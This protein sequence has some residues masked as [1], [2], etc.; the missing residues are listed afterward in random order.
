M[1][2]HGFDPVYLIAFG[3]ALFALEAVITS[4]VVIWFAVASLIV[5]LASFAFDMSLSVQIGAISIIG[6]ALLLWLRTSMYAKFMAAKGEEAKDIF[7]DE[8]GTGVISNG[9]VHYKSV[10]WSFESD[11]AFEEGEK[12]KVISASSGKAVIEK[13]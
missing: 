10:Y 7:L 3:I 11:D 6:M 2:E 12:V 8:V 1:F 4:F 13:L 5:G 9:M